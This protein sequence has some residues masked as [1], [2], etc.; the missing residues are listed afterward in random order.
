LKFS[1]DTKYRGEVGAHPQN[2]KLK[3]PVLEAVS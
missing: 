1:R 3:P 2:K